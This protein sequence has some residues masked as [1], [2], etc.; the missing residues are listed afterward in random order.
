MGTI[1]TV[2][3]QGQATNIK[4]SEELNTMLDYLNKNVSGRTHFAAI[5]KHVSGTTGKNGCVTPHV[6]DMVVF[7]FPKYSVYLAKRKQRVENIDVASFVRDL[8]NGKNAKKETLIQEI[9]R[10]LN[11]E[12]IIDV[13]EIAK[14]EVLQSCNRE[15]GHGAGQR[16]AHDR[17][18]AS[19]TLLCGI[20]IK[21]K[22]KTVF[23]KLSKHMEPVEDLN[24]MLEVAG[25]VLPFYEYSRKTL[26][27]GDWKEVNSRVNTLIKNEID[28]QT[29]IRSWKNVN[30]AKGNFDSVSV[31]SLKILGIVRETETAI[32]DA[33]LASVIA[34]IGGVTIGPIA[35]LEKEAKQQE[36]ASMAV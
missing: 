16:D 11:G 35:T 36:G 10:K 18:Y 8:R 15:G 2:E 1:R 3:Y 28:R 33:E 9:F 6:S 27:K 12:N 26:V 24:G 31:D 17:L 21:L 19:V 30:L 7:T 5:H 13:F 14:K 32:D 23:D 29:G 25:V 4:L 20:D 34:E 22:V